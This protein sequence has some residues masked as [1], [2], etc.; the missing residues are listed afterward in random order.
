MAQ[1][2]TTIDVLVVPSPADSQLTITNLTGHP[3][4]IL[5]NGIRGRDAP[6]PPAVDRDDEDRIAGPG[7]PVGLT[8]LGNLYHDAA[9]L[10]FAHQYQIAAGFL[11]RQPP[12]FACA[13]H[14][15]SSIEL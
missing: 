14:R 1:I 3:A 4:V 15:A 13:R 9:L 7:T 2:F 10:A 6:K 12:G 8:F 11:N 5:P